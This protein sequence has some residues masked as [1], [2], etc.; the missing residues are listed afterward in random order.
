MA[1]DSTN[2][3]T[4]LR[5]AIPNAES[6]RERVRSLSA[7]L[8]RG[9]RALHLRF[10]RSED[11]PLGKHLTGLDE[12]YVR[13]KAKDI[14]EA[15]LDTIVERADAIEK[16][17]RSGGPLRRLFENG[18]LLLELVL[19]VRRGRYREAPVWTLSAVGVALLYVL[20]PLDLIPD[21]L[22]LLGL[23][24]DAAVVS[25]CLSL[26]EQDLRKYRR[27]RQAHPDESVLEDA[28]DDPEELT[29]P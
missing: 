8:K 26:V 12:D 18:R 2:V 1:S 16:R 22:P 13:E 27:W 24:D 7:P 25:A 10:Q 19:D 28:D 9:A 21:T 6:L 14:T 29:S 4:R 3:R 11:K 17:F 20:N 5:K 23:V 15:D